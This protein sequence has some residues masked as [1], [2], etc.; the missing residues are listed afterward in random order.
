[1]NFEPNVFHIVLRKGTMLSEINKGSARL[2]RRKESARGRVLACACLLLF[3]LTPADLVW[4]QSSIDESR[5]SSEA[6]S[7]VPSEDLLSSPDAAD[8]TPETGELPPP[9]SSQEPLRSFLEIGLHGS[10]GV[11]TNPAGI[12]GSS[13]Q[14]SSLTHLFGSL[15]LLKVR[16]RSETAVDYM[17]GGA[18]WDG[19]ATSG[20][21]NQQQ[22]TAS[23]RLR[24]P[25]SQFI[26]S[27]TL[28]YLGEGDLVG[29]IVAGSGSNDL[30]TADS[31]NQPTQVSRQAY[32]THV[33]TADFREALTRRSSA[34][35]GVSYSL[36]N[37]LENGES[38]FNNR[39]ASIVAAFNH[40]L[41][42]K[43]SVGIAYR[44]QN[45]EF[46]NSNVGQ[47]FA[48]STMF[49]FHRTMSA[50]MDFVVGAGPELVTT[51]GSSQPGTSQINVSAQASLLY[52][53]KRSGV[54]LAYNRLVTSGADVYAGANSNIGS[55]S[56]YRDIF[57]SWRATVN[58]G[59]TRATSI[60]L[61]SATIPGN[62][63]SYGFLGT[64]IR[65][66]F[67][68]AL[69]G[70][71]SYQFYNENFG[72]CSGMNPCSIQTSRHIILIGL[73]WYL[74]RIPLD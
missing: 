25:K 51:R 11:D 68:S 54:S 31:D 72:N 67:G 30:L 69:N 18:F 12:L 59:Y 70:F 6:Q 46:P 57:R 66:R 64:T 62:S 74:R 65:R 50:R 28:R 8:A 22:F 4:A 60:N 16:A 9:A 1:M 32:I 35:V 5:P 36:T 34:N 43:D 40:H 2:A 7:E 10:E 27:D 20:H 23:E 37:Y 33:S 14:L 55:A 73:D 19:T 13:S 24:W 41:D 52:R 15:S 48:N 29:P 61:I 26:L 71:A 39:Q 47:L 63:Y 21:Y 44:F 45:L 3:F 49:I 17:G 53:R 58:G 38:A 56:A 42:R